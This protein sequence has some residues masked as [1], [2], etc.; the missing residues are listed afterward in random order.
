[1]KT[2]KSPIRKL[3]HVIQVGY[4]SKSLNFPGIVIYFDCKPS[5]IKF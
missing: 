5:Q 4:Y 1:M 3:P 2:Q